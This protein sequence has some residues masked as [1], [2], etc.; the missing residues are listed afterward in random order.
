MQLADA[1]RHRRS[2]RKFTERAPSRDELQLMVDAATWAPNHRLTQPWRFAV[3]GPEAR[4][5]YG[6]AL[7]NRKAKKAANETDAERIRTETAASHRAQPC[8]V[9]VSMTLNDNMEIREEDYAATMMAVQNF[10]LTAVSIGLGT[11]IRTGAIMDDP[12]ARAAAG[13]EDGERIV[14]VLTVGEPAEV[15]EAKARRAAAELLRWME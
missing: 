9:I 5:S 15:P 3:L 2:I 14:A 10:M 12:A 1:I 7:G 13:T 11:H 6:L 4:A 8:M